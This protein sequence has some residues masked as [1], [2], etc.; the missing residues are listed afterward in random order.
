VFV[1]QLSSWSHIMP[2]LT[3]GRELAQR[4]YAVVFASWSPWTTRVAALVA[5]LPRFSVADLG[6]N[7]LDLGQVPDFVNFVSEPATFAGLFRLSFEHTWSPLL[8]GLLRHFPDDAPRGSPQRPALMVCDYFAEACMDFAARRPGELDAFVVMSPCSPEHFGLHN[9][10]FIPFWTLDPPYAL[11]SLSLVDRWRSSVAL[12][13]EYRWRLAQ[14]DAWKNEQRLAAGLD[15]PPAAQLTRLAG[16][17]V[18]VEDWWLLSHPR[19]MPPLFHL[20]GPT[21]DHYQG[22]VARLPPVFRDLLAANADRGVVVISLG[23]QVPMQRAWVTALLEGLDQPLS[24]FAQPPLLLFSTKTTPAPH[25]IFPADSE[26][27][28]CFDW[29]PQADLVAHPLTVLVISHGGQASTLEAVFNAKPLLTIPI[30]GDQPRN[31]G[32]LADKKLALYLDKHSFTAADVR[33]AVHRLFT[34]PEFAASRQRYQ[35]LARIRN[36]HSAL[37]G[38]D[39]IEE[40]LLVGAQH[41]QSVDQLLPLWYLYNLDLLAVV[42]LAPWLFLAPLWWCCCSR[43]RRPPT[44]AASAP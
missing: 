8:R 10:W 2:M 26:R 15:V 43:R 31:A 29:L 14:L 25:R 3:Y 22:Q 41:L 11:S 23:S 34:D 17:H 40:A 44:T 38:A 30:F 16:H 12:P 24:G 18:L 20:N 5:D 35:A 33:Q 21:G 19:D 28:R 27:S 13:L 42:L 7:P 1:H 4:G 32:T 6:P 37:R 39:V 9:P 36:Q